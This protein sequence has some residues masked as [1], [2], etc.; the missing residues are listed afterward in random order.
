MTYDV[1]AE[2]RTR[3]RR[4]VS[5]TVAIVLALGAFVAGGWLLA[6]RAPS[7]PVAA[8][9]GAATVSPAGASGPSATPDAALPNDLTWS[10]VDGVALP[11]SPSSGPH[12]TSG[13]LA[14]GFT[15]DAGGAVL[16][17]VHLLV[18]V[19]PQVG[20][21][22]FDPTLRTQV[23]GPD[24]ASMRV[25][26]AQQYEVLRAQ[27][28]VAYGQPVGR[29]YA[30]LRGYRVDTYGPASA[31][32]Q[33]LTS[34]VDDTGATVYTAARVQL[35]WTGTDWALVAPPGGTWQHIVV[36]VPAEQVTTFTPF[37]G[38]GR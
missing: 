29:L 20:P 31:Q 23:V 1:I 25:Q 10:D 17:A 3:T 5:A 9:R 11:V 24:A 7:D 28:Q 18:R 15:H 32:L 27:A 19:C 22:V 6:A 14:R 30:T 37:P 8:D 13:N 4:R 26:V 33:V 34:T 16:A 12:D 35:T 2:A 38:A 36:L 21:D